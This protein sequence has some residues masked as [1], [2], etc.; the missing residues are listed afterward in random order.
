MGLSYKTGSL[1]NA[2]EGSILA[3]SCN[4]KGRWRS[5][6][7]KEFSQKFPEANEKYTLS[8]QSKGDALLG[9][10]E[11]FPEKSYKVLCLYTSR[12]YGLQIDTPEDILRATE[13]AIAHYCEQTTDVVTVNS[14]LINSGLFKVPWLKT[15][16]IIKKYVEKYPNVS[17]V[18][19]EFAG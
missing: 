11:S 17:W 7:A 18:V 3:H 15:E 5:G 19:W 4:C 8:C 13:K 2:P 12:S 1:F 10:W 9:S 16:A 6:I 14:P